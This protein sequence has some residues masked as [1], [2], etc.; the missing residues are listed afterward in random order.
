MNIT[1]NFS[2]CYE[3]LTMSAILTATASS[4][5][6]KKA[7]SSGKDRKGK[8]G[9]HELEQITSDALEQFNEKQRRRYDIENEITSH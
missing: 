2:S 5:K 4:R 8:G 9:S 3:Y 1:I 6:S 7:K